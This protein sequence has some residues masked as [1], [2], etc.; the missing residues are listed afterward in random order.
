MPDRGEIWLVN[1]NPVQ[2]HEQAKV[3]PC[4]VISNDLMNSKLGLSIVVPLTGTGWFTSTG[5]L[6]PTMVEIAPPEGGL[7]KLSYTMAH[8]VRT[9]SHSRFAKRLGALSLTTLSQVVKS[10]QDIIAF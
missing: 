3:R 7:T 6:A 10:V 8:Q 9:V 2:G 1:L 5:K 4:L